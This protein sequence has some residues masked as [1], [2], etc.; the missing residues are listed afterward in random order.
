MN[1]DLMVGGFHSDGDAHKHS[2]KGCFSRLYAADSVKN[3]GNGNVNRP[4]NGG[5]CNSCRYWK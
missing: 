3:Y 4:Y 2:F 5:T 1:T